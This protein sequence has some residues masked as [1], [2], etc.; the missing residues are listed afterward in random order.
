MLPFQRLRTSAPQPFFL[1]P[2]SATASA[3]IR[4]PQSRLTRS[5][6]PSEA[7]NDQHLAFRGIQELTHS[8]PPSQASNDQ[9]LAVQGIHGLTRSTSPSS[10]R[11]APW[12]LPGSS[13]AIPLQRL[14][15]V[16]GAWSSAC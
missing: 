9:Y 8:T 3:M 2:S 11:A 14:F 1:S 5:T 6:S 10:A 7:F 13:V 12:Q 4:I 16:L 15:E